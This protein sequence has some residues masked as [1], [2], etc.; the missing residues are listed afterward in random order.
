MK[1]QRMNH[2]HCVWHTAW[3]HCHHEGWWRSW[4]W[5]GVEWTLQQPL[6]THLGNGKFVVNSRINKKKK[7]AVLGRSPKIFPSGFTVSVERTDS[8]SPLVSCWYFVDSRSSPGSSA[9][10]RTENFYLIF[11]FVFP[12]TFPPF[13]VHLRVC[14]SVVSLFLLLIFFHFLIV[15]LVFRVLMWFFN[16]N[17]GIFRCVILLLSLSISFLFLFFLP[18][19]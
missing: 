15:P 12:S 8:A 2:Q 3:G 17:C 10:W 13:S 14:V 1:S 19:F 6:A 16:L 7:N 4:E 5:G 18:E 9:T 11:P